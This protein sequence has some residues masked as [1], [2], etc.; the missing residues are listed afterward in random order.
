[1]VNIPDY[2]RE[3]VALYVAYSDSVTSIFVASFV[4]IFSSKEKAL[5]WVKEHDPEN[6]DCYHTEKAKFVA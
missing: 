4:A 5:E 1:M 6:E 2:E 3:V